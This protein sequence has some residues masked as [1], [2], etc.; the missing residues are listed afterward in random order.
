MEIANSLITLFSVLVGAGIAYWVNVRTQRRQRIEDVFHE[1][2]AA[3]AVAEASHDFITQLGPWQGATE[4]EYRAATSQLGREGHANYVR[5]VA[6][7][8]ATLARAS[9]YQPALTPFYQANTADVYERASEIKAILRQGP[10]R[11]G[12]LTGTSLATSR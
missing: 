5:A 3:V 12:W 8:R 7:A 11:G 6:N 4:Q 9:A 10:P 2:L 1:A